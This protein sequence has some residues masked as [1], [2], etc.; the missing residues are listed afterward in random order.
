M[1]ADPRGQRHLPSVAMA[2]LAALLV[3]VAGAAAGAS[4]LDQ[5]KSFLSGAKTGKATFRQVVTSQRG[6]TETTGT[7]TFQ[8][9]GKFRWVYEKPYEQLI[10][11]DGE[12][13]WIYDRDLNQVIVRKLDAALG[14]SPA[15]LLSGDN[16]LERNF[17]LAGS[18]N[19]DGLEW[20]NAK[21]K[22]ADTGFERV[23]LGFKDNLPRVM[24]L[25]D[26]FGNVTRLEF[27]TFER[28]S[29]LDAGQFKFV[30][31]KGAD[32]VGATD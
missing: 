12:K 22:A 17:E 7:F 11:G 14:S 10:V 27:G 29:A 26:T 30:P 23:R 15:A 18:G 5:L 21:P 9:P 6:T 32:V 4:G 2:S 24:E 31:P 19:A 8:R 3:G 25:K 1:R 28:N 13:L 20:V 16:A